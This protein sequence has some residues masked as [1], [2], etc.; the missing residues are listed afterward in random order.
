MI[1]YSTTYNGG[2]GPLPN[3][4]IRTNTRLTDELVLPDFFSDK[5]GYG[6]F[7]SL[8]GD[9]KDAEEGYNANGISHFC[10]RISSKNGV[11]I[12]C[13][14]L[15]IKGYVQKIS[16]GRKQGFRLKYY[17]YLA[18]L[19]TEMYF[20]MFFANHF[21]KNNQVV[22]EINKFI[23]ATKKGGSRK[24]SSKDFKPPKLAYYMATGSGK[25]IVMHINY[26]Q[27]L[28]YA[29]RNNIRIDNCVLITP[30]NQMTRQHIDEL[31]KSAIEAIE[32]NGL[33][34]ESYSSNSYIIKVVDMNKLKMRETKKGTGITIDISGFGSH[35]LVLVDEGHKGY[36]SEE[37]TWAHIREQMS[38]EGFVLEYSATF[39]QAVSS[40]QELYDTY[41][42]SILIDY[43]YRHFYRDGYGKDFFIINLDRIKLDEN[44]I[45]N[46]LLLANCLSFLGQLLVYKDK[47]DI[48]KKYSIE[49]P[50]WIFVGSK[51]SVSDKKTTSDIIDVVKFLEWVTTPINRSNVIE[52]I[53]AIIDG[54]SGIQDRDGNDIFARSY[55]EIL[56]PYKIRPSY[57]EEKEGL[58]YEQI[59]LDILRIIFK[60]SGSFGIELYKINETDGEIG[61][62]CGSHFFGVIDVGDRARL[63]IDI[64]KDLKQIRIH[65]DKITKSLFSSIT[66]EP[67]KINVLIGAK[68]FI[69]GWDTKRVAS[70]CLLNVGKNEGAQ[71]IQLFGRGVRLNGENNS[72]KRETNPIKE[73]RIVQMLYIFGLKA[74]YLTVFRDIVKN[75]VL[76]TL[77]TLEIT[78]NKKNINPPLQM[79]TLNEK[80]INQYQNE[81]MILTFEEDII[82][83]LNFLATAE[84]I[85]L[86]DSGIQSVT[87]Y[88]KCILDQ[89]ILEILNWN[90]IYFKVLDYKFSSNFRNLIISP[91]NF[92]FLVNHLFYNNYPNYELSMDP[93]LCKNIDLNKVEI[94]E[95]AIFEVIKRY[96]FKFNDKKFREK[97]VP[98]S[99]IFESGNFDGPIPKNYKLY[100]EDTIA[101]KNI[102]SDIVNIKN[103]EEYQSLP[104]KRVRTTYDGGE[105]SLYVPLIS[106]DESG[107]C[108][109]IPVGLN[110]GEEK[111]VSDLI[112]FIETNKNIGS[113]DLDT[114]E[115]YLY[116]NPTR[117]GFHFYILN[118]TIYPDFVLWVRQKGDK[119]KNQ[120]IIYIE[121]HGLVHSD[122]NNDPKLNLPDYLDKMKNNIKGLD[123][124]AFI[125]S[126]TKWDKLNWK[127]KTKSQLEKGGIVFQSEQNYI[128]KI[129]KSALKKI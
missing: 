111:F 108:Y 101:D 107:K 14:D 116:R 11:E 43:S 106:Y 44:N 68:K 113:T 63:L 110:Q 72:M 54:Q 84:R 105:V 41:A 1:Q 22:N 67:E 13:Y 53:K 28:E 18:V 128:K 23:D 80:V 27:Y 49:R 62:K 34:L 24:L 97:I 124:Y 6:S 76:Y 31:N 39:E 129:L 26:L 12:S 69:E 89:S 7:S 99:N 36:K 92:D 50:L 122:L 127:H 78:D 20:E 112:S 10:E 115:F 74:S 86:T 47:K 82:P 5:L 73:L 25:T 114:L 17:Q 85:S 57:T 51:V 21:S 35:N 102:T 32:F 88:K 77:R 120:V 90:N 33:T 91:E 56:F 79:I 4:N 103:L 65:E 61:I 119:N 55:D 64:K 100:V 45:R 52:R 48:I 117:S 8:L 58:D 94:I 2:W 59:Y 29:K 46:T 60:S 19:F 81:S 16:I 40:D 121:P 9:L 42:H 95:E 38:L 83:S 109:T 71:I 75:E 98:G 30:S 3:K 96:I 123:A 15:K 37:R 125:I 70:I 93:E 87:E 118:E 104:I 66:D 126:V